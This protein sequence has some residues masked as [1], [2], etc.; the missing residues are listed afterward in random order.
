MFQYKRIL[1]PL[2]GSRRAETAL[3]PAL[4]L[5]KAFSAE[6]T[7]L[8]VVPTLKLVAPFV[9]V[10]LSSKEAQAD[11]KRQ[12]SNYLKGL[13][14][15]NKEEGVVMKTAVSTGRAAAGIIQYA[16]ENETDL[17]VL[18]SHGGTGMGRW[19]YGE[20]AMKLLLSAPC[21]TLVVRS[22]DDHQPLQFKRIMIPLDGSEE[23]E[24][25]IEPTTAIATQMDAEIIMVRVTAPI[26]KAVGVEN[27]KAFASQI[28]NQ[29]ERYLQTVRKRFEGTQATINTQV[30]SG[31]VA[32]S[33][34]T[35]AQDDQIDLIALT[36][37]GASGEEAVSPLGGVA[38]KVLRGAK[39]A[40]MIIR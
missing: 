15:V 25:A 10:E 38:D 27:A 5:S 22:D 28:K 34:L 32:Q 13:R 8:R 39:Q 17:I 33:I 31:P 7:L 14:M 6:I 29:V 30:E 1:V 11:H 12:A 40:V 37:H 16:Q 23:A 26:Q 36:A 4:L 9:Q 18:A 20:I 3:L 35:Y 24:R 21:S 19:R 2:D